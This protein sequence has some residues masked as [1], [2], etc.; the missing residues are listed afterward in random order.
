[1]HLG[2]VVLGVAV[3]SASAD[4]VS[5]GSAIESENGNVMSRSVIESGIGGGSGSGSGSGSRRND[6]MG[7]TRVALS[8]VKQLASQDMV[9]AEMYANV[10]AKAEAKAEAKVEAKASSKAS[11]N[12]SNKIE[13]SQIPIPYMDVGSPQEPSAYG[14]S[15]LGSMGS[16]PGLRGVNNVAGNVL[17]S[18]AL[19]PSSPQLTEGFGEELMSQQRVLQQ[20]QQDIAYQELMISKAQDYSNK[21]NSKIKDDKAI[22]AANK[23]IFKSWQTAVS[24]NADNFKAQ[25]FNMHPTGEGYKRKFHR[26]KKKSSGKSGS[27]LGVAKKVGSGL[28]NAG[29]KL[30]G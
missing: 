6:A 3:A 13:A 21:L 5:I 7:V 29:K 1:M 11:V 23:G 19:A 15:G 16:P 8:L 2:L 27:L 17:D 28:L 18:L 10:E 12:A 30:F 20:M 25:V 9:L 4:G 24:Q 14:T 26:S 22:L